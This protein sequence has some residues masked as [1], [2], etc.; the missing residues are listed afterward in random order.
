[1]IPNNKLKSENPFDDKSFDIVVCLATIE[2]IG[3]HEQQR[4]FI[5][6]LCRVGH[7]CFITTPNR[8]YPLEFHTVLPFVHWLPN[9]WFRAILKFLGK[10][11]YANENNLNLLSKKELI[12]LLP[13]NVIVHVRYFR[14]FGMVSNLMF[15]VENQTDIAFKAIT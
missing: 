8:W 3:S 11:F 14:L 2:H 12:C 6:D 4:A 1:M 9:P 10:H 5:H 15:F 13:K 7:T